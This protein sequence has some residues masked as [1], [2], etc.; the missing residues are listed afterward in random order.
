[1]KIFELY[2]TIDKALNA[3]IRPAAV[4]LSLFVAVALTLGICARI[5]MGSPM[6]GLEELVLIAVVWLYMIGA[7]LASRERS[8]LSADFILVFTK[9]KKIIAGCHLV[10]SLISLVMA[11]LFVT[12]SYDLFVWAIHKKQVTAVFSLPWYISQG[13]LLFAAIFF[14]YYIL[15]DVVNDLMT[16]LEK[17]NQEESA[18][19]C[20]PEK[21]S[22]E[23]IKG[24]C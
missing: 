7:I 8:H 18:E 24:D 11:V 13:S 21:T 5:V 14:V 19:D 10:S 23:P 22:P 20:L 12:W 6:F 16:L 17:N 15:R 3:F 1:M 4:V 2:M 9:N